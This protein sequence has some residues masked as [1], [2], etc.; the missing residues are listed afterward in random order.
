M[1]EI[2]EMSKQ[3]LIANKGMYIKLINKKKKTGERHQSCN[4]G[5]VMSISAAF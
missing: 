2:I 4:T 3:P 5:N 1:I